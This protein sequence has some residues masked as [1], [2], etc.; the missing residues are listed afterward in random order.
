MARTHPWEVSD[1]FWGLVEPLL[2][3]TRREA[4][5][6]YKRRSGGG[7]KAKYSDRSYFA[8][9]VYVLRTGIIWN[10]FSRE[11]FGGLGSS[12]LHAR[13]QHWAK[14]GLFQAIW[15]KGLAEYDEME[16]IAWEWQSADGTLV[17]APLA[18]ESVGPNPTDRG[19]KWQQATRPRRR[20]WR[21]A[22]AHRQRSEHARR[23][24]DRRTAGRQ[25]GSS[26]RRSGDRKPLP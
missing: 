4:G 3:K 9:I 11:K 17:E 20:A 14:A 1:E 26:G 5:R 15:R 13:F 23:Q 18:Q 7:R 22:V 2:P 21:P 10:A 8:G 25:G 19:K 16:G 24:E 12:A 6:I